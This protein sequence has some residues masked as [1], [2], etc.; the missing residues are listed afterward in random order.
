MDFVYE[1]RT[2]DPEAV[3]KLL[4]LTDLDFAGEVKGY[5]KN[6][7]AGFSGKSIMTID[8][9]SFEDSVFALNKA[10]AELIHKNNYSDYSKL[11]AGSFVPFTSTI[12]FKAEKIRVSGS[13]YDSVAALI[14]LAN[15]I[16]DV[17]ISGGRDS[18]EVDISFNNI[19][20]LQ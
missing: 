14:E 16:Q 15:G 18:F 19:A 11:P 13:V 10:S 1:F 3:S 5:I 17:N 2:K 20:S 7:P 9:F 6:S 4:F 12:D 8:K